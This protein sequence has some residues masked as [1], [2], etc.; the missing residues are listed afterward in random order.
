MNTLSN[1]T[2][3][4]R[5]AWSLPD[6]A[7]DL[8]V[9]VPFLRLELRRGRLRAARLGRRV[10]ILDEEVRRYLAAASNEPG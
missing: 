6:L 4:S 1:V 5:L 9:S 3:Q 10:V 7:R 8:S 2:D